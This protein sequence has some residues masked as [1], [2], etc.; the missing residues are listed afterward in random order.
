MHVAD[1]MPTFLEL[2][3]TTYPKTLR[4]RNCRR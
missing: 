1:L 3:G 2:A 4:A